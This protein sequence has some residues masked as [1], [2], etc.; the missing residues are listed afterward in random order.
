M[1]AVLIS[2]HFIF[3]VELDEDPTSLIL[4]TFQITSLRSPLLFHLEYMPDETLM[5][6]KTG[7]ASRQGRFGRASRA[8]AQRPEITGAG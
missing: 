7:V 1:Q 8:D 4:T 3:R 5:N 2:P 6:R